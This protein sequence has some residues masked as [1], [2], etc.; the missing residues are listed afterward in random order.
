LEPLK[1]TVLYIE[2]EPVSFA[3]VQTLLESHPGVQLVRGHTGAEGI[4]LARSEQPDVVLLD[5]HLGDISGIEVVR[6]LSREIA[7]GLF[8]VILLTS[9][10]LNIDVLKAMS[11]GASEYLVKPVSQLV[12]ES[13]LLRALAFQERKKPPN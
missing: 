10:R 3:M 9:D 6:Q 12:L 5:M 2:D 8:R 11:L 13:A 4:G 7:A 1:G